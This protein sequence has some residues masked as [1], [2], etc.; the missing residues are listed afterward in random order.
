MK[1]Q[2][3]TV[4]LVKA[5]TKNISRKIKILSPKKK[6]GIHTNL[7]AQEYSQGSA[8]Q[9]ANAVAHIRD[10]YP[11]KAV[12][13]LAER[14]GISQEILVKSVGLSARTIRSRKNKLTPLESDRLVRI[15]QVFGEACDVLRDEERVRRWF[16]KPAFGLGGAKPIDMQQIFLLIEDYAN[17]ANAKNSQFI[18][19][20]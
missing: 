2:A 5:P 6:S 16:N 3:E 11:K 13:D 4:Q 12:T 17:E 14:L 19:C 9:F 7:K 1:G 20:L 18:V 15:E 10:G 8:P